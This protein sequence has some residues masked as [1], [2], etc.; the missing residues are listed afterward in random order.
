MRFIVFL[1]CISAIGSDFYDVQ[2]VYL[3]YPSDLVRDIWIYGWF[4]FTLVLADREMMMAV[5][6]IFFSF[7][8]S[9]FCVLFVLAVSSI[10]LTYHLL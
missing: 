6:L 2:H 5:D 1:L 9:S 3:T 10:R 8:L 7:S 4:V